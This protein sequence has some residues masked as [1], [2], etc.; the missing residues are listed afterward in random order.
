MSNT[1][2][3]VPA[4]CPKPKNVLARAKRVYQCPSTP[5]FFLSSSSLRVTRNIVADGENGCRDLSLQQAGQSLDSSFSTHLPRPS[6]RRV[7]HENTKRP[8]VAEHE[9]QLSQPLWLAASPN[10][11]C[12]CLNIFNHPESLAPVLQHQSLAQHF[13]FP[14]R[15]SFTD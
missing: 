5:R 6:I 1:E 14:P 11:E 4:R 13:S 15:L 12:S 10:S 8:S 3:V 7:C 2:R 9:P